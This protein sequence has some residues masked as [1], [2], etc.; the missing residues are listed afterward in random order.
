MGV[1]I[2]WAEFYADLRRCQEV[3]RSNPWFSQNR[4]FFNANYANVLIT[5]MSLR[6]FAYS[7]HSRSKAGDLSSD[8]AETINSNLAQVHALWAAFARLL[9]RRSMIPSHHIHH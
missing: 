3:E 2:H 7:R 9:L 8:N 5:R 6:K 4:K 1:S